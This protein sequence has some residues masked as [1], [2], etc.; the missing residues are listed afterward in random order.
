M[1]QSYCKYIK[2]GIESEAAENG[3]RLGDAVPFTKGARENHSE[4]K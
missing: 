3:Q 4:Q 2:I 1:G